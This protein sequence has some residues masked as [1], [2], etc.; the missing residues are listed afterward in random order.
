M[1]EH[2]KEEKTLDREN[3]IGC[4]LSNYVEAIENICISKE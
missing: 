3:I 2:S 1:I 4:N